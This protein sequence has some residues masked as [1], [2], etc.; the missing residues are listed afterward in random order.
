MKTPEQ[1]AQESDFMAAEDW[2]KC[3]YAKALL[4]LPIERAREMMFEVFRAGHAAGKQDERERWAAR[5]LDFRN[6][7]GVVYLTATDE[8]D[9]RA[10][11]KL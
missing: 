10:K 9:E 2:I 7:G 6:R 4:S 5:Y 3:D 11:E 8:M 1:Q